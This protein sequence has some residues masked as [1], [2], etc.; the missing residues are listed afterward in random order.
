[1]GRFQDRLIHSDYHSEFGVVNRSRESV[2]RADV[3]RE[4]NCTLMYG[5]RRLLELGVWPFVDSD[6]GITLLCFGVPLILLL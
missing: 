5:L 4:S 1:V 2:F 6:V 3:L